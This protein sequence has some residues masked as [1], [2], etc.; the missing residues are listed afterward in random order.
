MGCQEEKEFEN[1]RKQFSPFICGYRETPREKVYWAARNMSVGL[2]RQVKMN[3]NQIFPVLKTG[4]VIREVIS[5][6]T[7]VL[8]ARVI[9]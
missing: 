3:Q 6:Q 5:R 7:Q 2:R 8:K 9:S 1:K 4:K